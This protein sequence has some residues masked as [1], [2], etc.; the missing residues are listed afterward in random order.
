[1]ERK[2]SEPIGNLIQQFLRINGL[3]TPYNEHRIV[4]AWPVVMGN[5]ISQYT[6]EVFVKNQVLHVKV[7]S[8]AIKQ[9]LMM[10]R[11]NLVQRLNQYVDAQVIEDIHF[12]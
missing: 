5:F 4:E 8:P 2:Q 6:K 7:T 12:Y 1:M 10:E 3:E 11:K 9:N